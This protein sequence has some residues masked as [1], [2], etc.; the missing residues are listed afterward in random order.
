MLYLKKSSEKGCCMVLETRSLVRSLTLT[1]WNRDL[2]QTR[3][4]H[5]PLVQRNSIYMIDRIGT[6]QPRNRWGKSVTPGTI[7]KTGYGQSPKPTL[8]PESQR[9]VH[10]LSASL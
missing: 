4:K 3:M 7:L 9:V 2:K 5:K 1:F 10:K 8:A 6:F